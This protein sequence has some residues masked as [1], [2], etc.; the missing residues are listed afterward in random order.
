[1][2]WGIYYLRMNPS[3]IY[4]LNIILFAAAI[5]FLAWNDQILLLPF[6]ALLPFLW[7]EAPTRIQAGLAALV[8]Y[9][10]AARGLP[11]GTQVFFG[12]DAPPYFGYAL[13]AGASLLLALP[14]FALWSREL[15]PRAVA[16]R[17]PLAL[18]L[19]ALPPIGIFGWAHPL[20]AAGALF[21]GW[22]WG[23]L[24]ALCALMYWSCIMRGIGRP[25]LAAAVV[26][27]YA[28]AFMH[29]E[30][31][32][33]WRG[34]DTE[35][36]GT[37]LSGQQA[38]ANYIMRAYDTNTGLIERTAK[39]PARSI[40]LYPESLAG[41]WTPTTADLWR[42]AADRLIA[43]G[44]TVMLG[45]EVFHPSGKYDNVI[46]SVGSDAGIKYRQRMPVPISMWR[47]YSNQGAV[48]HWFDAGVFEL[49]GQRVAA[50]I[51]YEQLL[52]W[53]AL[54]S[55]AHNPQVIV[56]PSNAWWSRDTS[57][58]DIQRTALRAWARLF[59]VPLVTAFNI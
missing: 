3:D 5:G 52:V 55:L 41:P 8:Y 11:H 54:V 29:A 45:A 13:W 58:P 12:A 19:T 32:A 24:A 42:P 37:V 38:L 21:P 35:Y 46:I 10:A 36:G 9:L 30:K 27:A 23:G 16:W 34:I 20:T 28:L 6:A 18:A 43:K 40:A 4:G 51:C 14:W 53:P 2:R 56:A 26:A 39:L 33:A 48:A 7:A 1:M 49:H 57:I 22:S 47:P 31:P 17:M 59:D 15:T 25:L 44:S 50:L